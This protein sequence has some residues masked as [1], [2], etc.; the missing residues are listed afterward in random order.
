MRLLTPR[1]GVHQILKPA[2]S[3]SVWAVVGEQWWAVVGAW[4]RWPVLSRQ[5][6]QFGRN[7][8]FMYPLRAWDGASISRFLIEATATKIPSRPTGA[9]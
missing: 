7:Q 4:L 1:R 5:S 2:S 3:I 6:W 9:T 8:E